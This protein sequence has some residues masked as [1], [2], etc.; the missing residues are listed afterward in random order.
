MRLI[1]VREA[2]EQIGVSDETVRTWMHRVED[3]IPS[4]VVGKSGRNR[5][6]IAE[7]IGPWLA[8]EASRKASTK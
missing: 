7:E 5:K 6:I 2:A 3:P 8:A 4:V 1:G